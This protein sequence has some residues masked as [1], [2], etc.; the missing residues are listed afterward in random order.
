MLVKKD[1]VSLLNELVQRYKS[2]LSPLNQPAAV[3]LR[4]A[5]DDLCLT[6]VLDA[7]GKLIPEVTLTFEVVLRP[8]IIVGFTI[9]LWWWKRIVRYY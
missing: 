4:E 2:I 1:H 5:E 8:C 9:L 6:G 3:T 7:A